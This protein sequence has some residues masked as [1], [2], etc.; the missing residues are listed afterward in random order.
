[1]LG[2]EAE[3]A[4]PGPK[5]GPNLGL[6]IGAAT[7]IALAEAAESGERV[8]VEEART[9][10]NTYFV[11]PDG[12]QT[13]ELSPVPVRVR[14]DAGDWQGV[15]PTLVE[16]PDG[17]VAT[18]A[19]PT[20]V[21]LSGGG[22]D[23]PLVR[24]AEGSEWMSLGWQGAL[25]EPVLDGP[26]A[27]YP[28]VL[29]GVDLVVE[30]GL[31]G[32]GQYLVVK[33]PEAAANPELA[34]IG[35][36][37][38]TSTGLQPTPDDAGG[39][40][41]N[42]GD[43]KPAFT[44]PVP[45]MWESAP[46]PATMTGR[47]MRTTDGS[48]DAV[49]APEPPSADV[50]G[51]GE[52]ED[53]AV[54]P[55]EVQGDTL[56]IT[57]DQDLLT[58]PA[59]VFPVVIDPSASRYHQY[60]HMVWSDGQTF[61][62]SATQ[63]ARVGY[64]GWQDMKRS[65]VFY[66]ID[67]RGLMNGPQ[68]LSA[69]FAHRQIHSPN[70]DCGATSFGPGV[71]LWFTDGIRPATGWPG[72]PIRT[73]VDTAYE[74]HGHENHCNNP[75]RTEWNATTIATQAAAEG[76]P[77][78][79]V[80]LKSADETDRNGWR[81]FENITNPAQTRYPVLTVDFNWPPSK[82]SNLNTTSP[83]T[84]CDAGNTRPWVTDN[85]PIVRAT[86]DDPDGDNVQMVVQYRRMTASADWVQLPATTPRSPGVI[87]LQ[88]PVLS[89]FSYQWRATA[90][91]GIGWSGWS[92]QTCEFSLD[93]I[94]PD[95]PPLITSSHYPEEQ[96]A[97]GIGEAGT[98]S[99]S[100]NG[101]PDVDKY[102]YSLNS[103]ALNRSVDNATLGGSASVN[104]APAE[105][106]P[107]TLY[108]QSVDRAG[109]VSPVATYVFMVGSSDPI[110]VWQMNE[111]SGTTV[112]DQTGGRNALTVSN[113]WGPDWRGAANPA[114][115]S[116]LF[117]DGAVGS[118][119]GGT[120]ASTSGP[121]LRND[122]PGYSVT[123]W[124]R[125]T[126]A[127]SV[128]TG[129]VIDHGGLN[130]Y[131]FRLGVT[132]GKW[133]FN[134][135]RSDV[136]SPTVTPVAAP[137]AT[138]GNNAWTHLAIVHNAAAKTLTLYVNGEPVASATNFTTIHSFAGPMLVGGAGTS[139]W[140]GNVDDVRVYPAPLDAQSVQRIM[141]DS[142][143]VPDLPEDV[144]A[145]D[146]QR[147]AS[148]AGSTILAGNINDPVLLGATRTAA[149]WPS[150]AQSTVRL[151]TAP[152]Q[153]AGLPV[154]VTALDQAGAVA[155]GTDLRVR[156]LDQ[157]T[158]QSAEVP[159]MLMQV[160]S[161]V[162]G[163]ALTG[164][165]RI[166]VDYSDFTDYGSDY[167]SRLALYQ[168][169]PCDPVA[170][171]VV[172]CEM[173]VLDSANDAG[174]K[175][176]TANVAVDAGGWFAVA[177]AASGPSG[178]YKATS[179][180]PS[181]TW[182]GGGSA[183]GF[184]WNYPLRVP[185]T[186]GGLNPELAI[187]Y[188]SAAVDGRVSST[189]NQ[190]SWIGEGHSLE[191][192]FIERRYAGCADD[193][194]SGANNTRKTGD[195]CWKTDTVHLTLDGRSTE[196]ILDTDGVTWRPVDDDGSRIEHLTGAENGDNDGEHWRITTADGTQYH[197]G[198]HKRDAADTQATNSTFTVPVAGNHAGEPCRA[199][200]FA[201]SFCQQAWRWN[202]DYVVDPDGNTIT[203]TYVK[204][205]NRYGQNLDDVSVAYTRGGYLKRIEYG[206]RA[207]SAHTTTAP[208]KVEFTVAERCLA[209]AADCEEADLTAGNAHRWPDVPFDQLCKSTSTCTTRT[210]P[211]F[212]SRMRLVAIE[213]SVLSGGSYDS[214]DRWELAHQFPD[215]GDGT[216]PALWLGRIVH[217]GLAGPTP[218]ELPSVVFHG[219]QTANRVDGIDNAPPFNKWRVRTIRNETGGRISVNYST[220][221]C[222]PTNLPSSPH[223]NTM[224]CF[225]VFYTPEGAAEP[226]LHWFHK[227]LV[228]S[229]VSDDQNDTGV[230][231]ETH[232]TY[233]G[234]PAWAYQDSELIPEDQRT[235]GDWRGYGTVVTTVGAGELNRQ[236]IKTSTLYMR[237]MDG[238]H[239]PSG[240]RNV[241]VVDSEGATI[242]D[243][244][245]LGGFVRETITY[246][247]DQ[248][249]SKAIHDPWRSAATASDGEQTAHIVQVGRTRT[250]TAVLPNGDWRTTDTVMTYDSYGLMTEKNDRG[251]TSTTEDDLCT[252][253][254]Y[255]RNT[256]LH[257]VDKPSRLETVSVACT[258]TPSRPADVVSD[259]RFGYDGEAVG[260]APTRGNATLNEELDTWA[261]GPSY[262]ANIRTTF[263]GYG[264]PTSTTDALDRTTTTAY[265]NVSTGLTQKVT[266][267]NPAGHASTTTMTT[268]H[269]NP[270]S[271]VDANGRTT[272]LQYDAL[273]R[274]TKVWEPDRS[275]SQTPTT[276]HVYSVRNN[277]VS[278]VATKTLLPSGAQ[279][280]GYELY[281][282]FG[283]TRQVQTPSASASE[284][285]RLI[286]DT[287]YDSR[288]LAVA[289]D[290]PYYNSAAPSASRFD[291]TGTVPASTRT[292]YDGA[293]RVVSSAFYENNTELWRTIT[294]Y[295]GD[296]TRVDPPNGDT[297]TAVFQDARG[298][299][300]RLLQYHGN[301]ASG[302]NDQTLYEYDAAGR[303]VW[304]RDPA[305]NVWTY[306]YDLRGRQIG[307]TDPD[308][309]AS[310]QTFD[311]A[312]QLLTST[313]AEG[314]TLAYTYDLLGRKTSTR[315]GSA[316]G[317][318]LGQWTYDTL[319]LGYLTSSSRREGN[320]VYTEAITSYDNG[321]RPRGT[322]VT[323]PSAEGDLAGTYTFTN[324][325]NADGSIA[326]SSMPAIG[327]LPAETLY[328]RYES[329]G[330][331]DWM[332]GYNTYA[333]DTIWSPYGEILRRGQ[334]QYGTASWQTNQYEAGTR[335]LLRSRID[336]EDQSVYSD[337]R[338]AYDD[339][340]NI[341]RMS[342]Q[343]AGG[344]AD[345]QC[346]EYDYLRRLAK[347][348]T[349][350][351][352]DCATPELP[353]TSGGTDNY[354]HEYTYDLTGNRTS[355]VRTR[356]SSAGTENLAT[357]TYAYPAAGSPQPHALTSSTMNS[358]TTS[359]TYD[360]TGN[361]LTAG[362]E[363]YAWDAEGRMKT[364]TNAS[365]QSSFT[366]TADGDRLVRRDPDSVTIYLPGHELELTTST[367][368][369]TARRYYSFAGETVAVRSPSGG[370]QD[371]YADH[372]GSSDTA[373]DA[374]S[375]TT[376]HK[377][378][379]PFGNYRGST[380]QVATY[381]TDRGF[382]TGIE[383]PATGLIQMGAR[384]YDPQFGRFLSVDPIVDHTMPQQM[385][386]YAYANNSPI[387]GSDPTGL[388]PT[389][390][391]DGP[392]GGFGT[393]AAGA[394]TGPLPDY[395]PL[396]GGAYKPG[397][398]LSNSN[399]GGGGCRWGFAC[400]AIDAVGD[401]VGGA[402]DWAGDKARDARD[403]VVGAAN[404]VKDHAGDAVRL[405]YDLTIGDFIDSC[406][407][408]FS[409]GAC[410]FS[411]FTTFTPTGRVL[412]GARIGLNAIRAAD[413]VVDA[414]NTAAR[415]CSFA[416]ATL[417]LMADGSRRAIEDIEI[418]DE[419]VAT[420]PE[421][422]EQAAKAVTHVW[423][424]EDTLV[425]LEVDDTTI[426]TTEDH[427][428]W[429]AS[430][431]EFQEASAI[432]TGDSVLTA[433]GRLLTVGGIDE[434]TAYDGLAY[435]LTIT[436][437]HTYHVGE[438]DVLVHNTNPGCS[439]SGA[440]ANSADFVASADGVVIPLSR[441][442]LEAGF[443]DAGFPSK[444]TSS[445]GTQYT[446]PD[447][448]IVRVM[449]P[450]GPHG[451]RATF[452]N[453]SHSHVNAF[454]GKPSHRPKGNPMSDKE[455]GR[456]RSHVTLR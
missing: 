4:D 195:L 178:D 32:F 143:G 351:D 421:T 344:T 97:G 44:V 366:Y 105:F 306:E 27:T 194:G 48:V 395:K 285:G 65:R 166:S 164:D 28:E 432:D 92:P 401:A 284:P 88:L 399:S 70:N 310:Q 22:A 202:L 238:D 41:I 454:T 162:D 160:T 409:L 258:A 77:A 308:T 378:R 63:D 138:A 259:Q 235:W 141:N 242:A 305:Q 158:A 212:F 58:D 53:S 243:H 324:T 346:F 215:P 353:P 50:V 250:F 179:L 111:G 249:I 171:P 410:A 316:T 328:H 20:E 16:Q 439:I 375:G 420:D 456:S 426:T 352:N 283:R 301:G 392:N 115:S 396:G 23:T 125:Y 221:E 120:P 417:V 354:H 428:F 295:R 30:A 331:E 93:T 293:G 263:D 387:T 433:D 14:D 232:Y 217:E 390:L 273:G 317:S 154:T 149:V 414:G 430:E 254:T 289:V 247:G 61:Y 109:N 177:S 335:R 230:A 119:A 106:G 128:P 360:N 287:E 377:D 35:F 427:P 296:H 453:S 292:A 52:G 437:I 33:T 135:T 117:T 43:G 40:M 326:T 73:L 102:Y 299:T 181:S 268:Y 224:N 83:P 334:G 155:A 190:S 342:D 318:V 220:P 228:T 8:E 338:Y 304:V 25:P 370:L 79:T 108:V 443:R 325:Y 362:S 39:L 282:G 152:V 136:A 422:G 90:T 264:R 402:R 314:R 71:E 288:G 146:Y 252:R 56:T 201:D 67:Y 209:A 100:A 151:A 253:T 144:E 176:V 445:P 147:T 332:Y 368:A 369:V 447:G 281:D 11:N 382:H 403:A 223:S 303:L 384:V 126:G 257:I 373:I 275:L 236:P 198:L 261:S 290:G 184:S 371:L 103:E 386:G 183:G 82:P 200:A 110:A 319:E 260:T 381:P 197:F 193:M 393:P 343:P 248:I 75:M 423:V 219:T 425:D 246:D 54:M 42:R 132:G 206:E 129:T 9:D 214:V 244:E 336:R 163:T 298:R 123:A 47:L 84:V 31:S 85:T 121:V 139:R 118:P 234:E 148:L 203:Y 286:T 389:N 320:A 431:Q 276:E 12:T 383:D 448:G 435:N 240:T 311:D 199:T 81:R 388:I 6:R 69:T 241:D 347:A 64:D 312:G 350:T 80:G 24:I 376:K 297:P 329:T 19:T 204:E 321:Y 168:I 444:P 450:S 348:F 15:D 134:A 323:V 150:A 170:D 330:A 355:L 131:A 137:T 436:D 172:I 46:E 49:P 237:G 130:A 345:I 270:V 361:T 34:E 107:N 340:G 188:S 13:A 363:S 229:V 186:A 267:T 262:V 394:L 256:S 62:N 127:S 434:G 55:I 96:W 222:T 116:L 357:T 372:N 114:S 255:A 349:A 78:F 185:P 91:D 429:N 405:I 412:Q 309:G 367:N 192:G 133:S 406:F 291:P 59:T 205:S 60:W 277:G 145:P 442:R 379:D 36:P 358:T 440:T 359:F 339:A 398:D 94:R 5:T 356:L 142:Q 38:Q 239:L 76:W 302:A 101:V 157:T 98:F 207:G 161:A 327:G 87:S 1:M 159:G 413:N 165:V 86:I 2:P 341:T 408:N 104:L 124:A 407:G 265:T 438:D 182:S 74:A 156:G 191:P 153:V 174:A 208:A 175:T 227:Y 196:M 313:D 380:G 72:P 226:D 451:T 180:A 21:V 245:R 364:T 3:P 17:T 167:G 89:D 374:D 231:Q 418:G 169:T 7:E 251:D 26:T 419:V 274:L 307:K 300:A 452:T 449:D 455:Y 213:T 400:G 29:P 113:F 187:D 45:R 280:I 37:L 415:L 337:V 225:P 68:I 315:Q 416:G 140:L 51:R 391:M 278:A 322:R 266:I 233:E 271:V 173:T 397:N 294:E 218:V 385:N 272:T 333:V 112:A 411:V 10:R 216:A 404:Y 66:A 57:P 210:S 95:R 18:V 122:L 441:S 365:G 99:F 279:A 189:N 446:L 211:T 269:G 424:H